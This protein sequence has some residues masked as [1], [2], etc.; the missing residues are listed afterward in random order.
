MKCDLWTVQCHGFTAIRK[1][2][3]TTDPHYPILATECFF[4]EKANVG[5]FFSRNERIFSR[6]S[7]KGLEKSPQLT[8]AS[9]DEART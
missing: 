8:V 5:S 7:A 1:N 4:D 6:F 3:H 2:L 9:E